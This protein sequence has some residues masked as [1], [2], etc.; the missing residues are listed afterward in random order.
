V[1]DVETPQLNRAQP[2]IQALV[3]AIFDEAVS[4]AKAGAKDLR[5]VRPT[6]WDVH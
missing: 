2:S 1:D 6:I 5:A 4:Q 3:M